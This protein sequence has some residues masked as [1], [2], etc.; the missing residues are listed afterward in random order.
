M[1]LHHIKT[2]E[3]FEEKVIKSDK[4]VLVDFY[5]TWCGPCKMVAPELE[6]LAPELDGTADIV[7]VDVEEIPDVARQY[8]IMSVPTILVIKNG[9]E[10]SRVV[11]FRPRAELKGMVERA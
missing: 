1:A 3:E 7:K 11:G 4:P 8:K 9:E 10:A 2:V 5:A 6:A